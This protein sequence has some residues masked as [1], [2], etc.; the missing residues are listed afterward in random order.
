MM[1]RILILYGTTEGQTAK[2]AEFIADSRP[3]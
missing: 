1:T 2:I 3:R